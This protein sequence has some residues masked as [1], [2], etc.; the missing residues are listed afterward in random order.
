ML[1]IRRFADASFLLSPS[2]LWDRNFAPINDI[3]VAG[4]KISGSAQSRRNS[5]FLQHGTLLLDV[6]VEKMFGV[7][8]ASKVKDAGRNIASAK[9][10]VTSLK[11][12]SG[13]SKQEVLSA[14]E[15]AFTYGRNCLPGTWSARELQ[16]AER[17]VS[18]RYGTTEWNFER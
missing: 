7:L 8:K 4:K 13:A 12:H 18:Q 17:L 16:E 6:D 2:S 3:L 5:V 10:R 9:E 11:E 1:P 14:L 15:K